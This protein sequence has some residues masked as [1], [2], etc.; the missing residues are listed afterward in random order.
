MR[1]MGVFSKAKDRV[2]EQMALTYLNGGP[3]EPYGKAT[4]LRV[5]STDKSIQ[6]EV[7]LKGETTPVQVELIDYDIRKQGER[8]LASVKEIRTSREWLTTLAQ[9]RF[10]NQRIE[11][12]DQVGRLLF[13]TL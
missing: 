13:V 3:L 11:L 7:E 6:I 9:T 4:R 5:N 10:C 2:L 1:T 8:Y 12:P